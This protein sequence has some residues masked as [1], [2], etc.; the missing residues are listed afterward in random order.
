MTANITLIAEARNVI[1]IELP[2]PNGFRVKPATRDHQSKLA[3]LWFAAY[4]PNIATSISE[5]EQEMSEMF[6][7]EY[8]QFWP[9]ASP[10]IFAGNELIAAICTVHKAPWEKTPTCPFIV[11]LMVHPQFRRRGVAT[12][13]VRETAR[14][15][16]REAHTHVALR[17]L[18][19]NTTAISLYRKLGFTD[20]NGVLF[21]PE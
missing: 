5:A 7:G 12:W 9:E 18:V 20:W 1:T 15:V 14:V 17:V 10:V 6:A 16:L 2:L 21:A 8:G 11:D 13:L 4:P 3:A 19:D